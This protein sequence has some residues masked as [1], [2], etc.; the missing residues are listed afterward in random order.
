M[1]GAKILFT[2]WELDKINI[3]IS[4]KISHIHIEMNAYKNGRITGSVMIMDGA[5]FNEADIDQTIDKLSD[6]IFKSYQLDEVNKN[7]TS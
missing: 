5:N 4:N 7:Q 1:E 3:E 2:A 6:Q